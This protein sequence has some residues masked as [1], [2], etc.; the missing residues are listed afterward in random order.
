MA[1][2]KSDLPGMW[3]CMFFQ[4][5]PEKFNALKWKLERM[6]VDSLFMNRELDVICFH[7]TTTTNAFLSSASTRKVYENRLQKLLDQGP[8]E[9]AAP[10]SEAS[11]TDGS[12]NGNTDSDQY[13]DKEEGNGKQFSSFELL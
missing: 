6:L 11:Q 4:L 10:P 9:A 2:S 7:S 1:I 8:P 5:G 12:Q 3:F 13:S